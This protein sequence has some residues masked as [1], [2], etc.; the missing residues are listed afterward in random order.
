MAQNSY[1]GLAQGLSVPGQS[2]QSIV[3][4]PLPT[5]APMVGAVK[6]NAPPVVQQNFPNMMIGGNRGPMVGTNPQM[7]GMQMHQMHQV[8]CDY[9]KEFKIGL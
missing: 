7:Q 6:P 8:C 3:R 9:C 5:G 2:T 1:Q 4:V